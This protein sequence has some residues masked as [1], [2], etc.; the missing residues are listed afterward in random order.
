MAWISFA[1]LITYLQTILTCVEIVTA[2][3]PPT[4]Y[5]LAEAVAVAAAA[6]GVLVIGKRVRAMAK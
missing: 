1:I 4:Y 5:V 3:Y 2:E 6:A